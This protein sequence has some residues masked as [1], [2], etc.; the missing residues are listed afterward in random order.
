MS[1]NQWRL[2]Y[3]YYTFGVLESPILGMVMQITDPKE[4]AVISWLAVE[5][6]WPYTINGWSLIRV[7]M[8]KERKNSFCYV[9]LTY[10]T[11]HH[12]RL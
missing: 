2:V 11:L 7:D 9:Y 1:T 5:V 3:P 8:I 12:L 6:K 4:G 10:L